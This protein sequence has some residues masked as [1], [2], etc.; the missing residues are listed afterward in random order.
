[1]GGNIKRNIHRSVS[2]DVVTVPL[3]LSLTSSNFHSWGGAFR[4]PRLV[5]I[6]KKYADVLCAHSLSEQ[7]VHFERF[8]R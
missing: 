3:S 5:Q 6:R 8:E 1:M 4:V 2:L 7:L